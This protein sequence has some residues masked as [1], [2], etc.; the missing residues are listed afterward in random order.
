MIDCFEG[1]DFP[2]LSQ[3]QYQAFLKMICELDGNILVM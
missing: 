2:T 3:P 1:K